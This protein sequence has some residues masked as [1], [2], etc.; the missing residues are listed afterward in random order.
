MNLIEQSREEQLKAIKRLHAL[1]EET[2]ITAASSERALAFL[3]G[4]YADEDG[5]T[6]DED[7]V[8]ALEED[9]ANIECLVTKIKETL[10]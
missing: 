3:L 9:L 10:K 1:F 6:L 2:A 4:E 5:S 8:Q 7:D